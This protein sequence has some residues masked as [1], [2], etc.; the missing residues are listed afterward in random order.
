M[1]HLPE[2]I[3]IPTVVFICVSVLISAI[4]F[5][6]IGQN[7][8]SRYVADRNNAGALFGFVF[9][10]GFVAVVVLFFVS[11]ASGI[12]SGIGLLWLLHT[13]IRMQRYA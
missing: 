10:C 13:M 12:A 7:W 5:A 6:L 1:G 8:A 4:M 2:V 3:V 11:T 9:G